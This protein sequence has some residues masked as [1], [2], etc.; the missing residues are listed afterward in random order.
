MLCM[1]CYMGSRSVI[2]HPADVTFPPN[3]NPNLNPKQQ[4]LPQTLT[5]TLT[6]T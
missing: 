4:L 1:L 2:C 3:A 6:L 5:L